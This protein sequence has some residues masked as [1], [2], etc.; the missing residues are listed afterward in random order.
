MR[1][2][3]SDCRDCGL[4][5]K[6]NACPYYRVEYFRCDFCKEDVTPLYEYNGYEICKDCLIK[7][8]E[9]IEGSDL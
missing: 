3:E 6:Y 4:P 2:Y 5:C 8:F 7:Q 9:I 1:I